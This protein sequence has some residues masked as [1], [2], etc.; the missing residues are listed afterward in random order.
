MIPKYSKRIFSRFQDLKCQPMH[1]LRVVL[2]GF[3]L[4]LLGNTLQAQ[5]RQPVSLSPEIN[6]LTTFKLNHVRLLKSPFEHAMELDS[7]YMLRLDTDRLLAPYLEAAGLESKAPNYGGWEST[8][9]R[10]HTLGHY[11]SAISM[12]Y[13]AT[14]N[15]EF[16][17]RTNYIVQ[18][19]KRAQDALGTG[20]IGGIPDHEQLFDS[21]K[22]GKIETENFSL[23]GVWSPWYNLHKAFAG[24]RDAYIYTGNDLA[25][26]VLTRYSDWAIDFA[27]H[28]DEEQ[29]QKMLECE[30][31]GMNEVLADVYRLTGERKY[32]DLAQRF[33]H[34]AVFDPLAEG[35][36][37]LRGLHANTQIPKIIGAAVQYEL[38]GDKRLKRIVENFWDEVVNKRSYVFGGNSYRE[39]FGELGTLH[40]R[41]GRSTAETCNTYNM[42]KLTLH[43][44]EWYPNETKY[45]DYYERALYNHILASQDPQ[46]GMMAYYT[47]TEPGTFKVFS[48]PFESFWCDVGT[49]MEDHAKY[50]ET[51]YLHSGSELQVNLFL[52]SELSWEEQGL[53]LRQET[54][55][56]NSEESRLVV[57]VEEPV[58]LAFKIRRPYWAGEGFGVKVNG[59]AIKASD[60]SDGFVTI[61]RTW[62]DGDTVDI[63]LPMDLHLEYMPNDNS[64]AAIMYGPLVL[65]GQLGRKYFFDP[66]PISL[67]NQSEYFD[68]PAVDVPKL[69]IGSRKVNEWVHPIQ[70]ESLRFVTDGVGVPKDVTLAP[71]YQVNRQHYTIYWDII[72]NT[73]RA[74]K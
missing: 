41:L 57:N 29:F 37:E 67:S 25:L 7:D 62:Q 26:T 4:L 35:R 1:L 49:G 18:E 11:L 5:P 9:L 30:F 69:N 36:D 70:G 65:A 6:K 24:L 3:G 55:F 32:L 45:A 40:N 19:L 33:N 27:S 66:M 28:L 46:T 74:I 44:M 68:V 14:G 64:K 12:M 60:T 56:P 54:D 34:K 2:V 61:R 58:K 13:A 31:G 42:L 53:T 59:R 73:E 48:N 22:A 21:L 38:T 50:G 8:E 63:A 71:F 15:R 20:Y 10:G 43:L 72:N 16:K 23:N 39:Y 52:P 17:N 51:I 47:S